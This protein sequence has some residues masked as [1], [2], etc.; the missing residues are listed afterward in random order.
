MNKSGLFIL[1]NL[2]YLLTAPPSHPI[3]KENCYWT[4][5]GQSFQFA[6]AIRFS[7]Q[8]NQLTAGCGGGVDCVSGP[9]SR[10]SRPSLTHYTTFV[11]GR[12]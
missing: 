9:L 10:G 5:H 11:Q 3:A 6:P 7:R 12:N 8:I 2:N 1:K 4:Y